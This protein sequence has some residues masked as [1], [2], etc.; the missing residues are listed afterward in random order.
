M[1]TEQTLSAEEHL[2]E[3][4]LTAQEKAWKFVKIFVVEI[5][6][7][8]G[9]EAILRVK[10]KYVLGVMFAL[11]TGVSVSSSS[12]SLSKVTTLWLRDSQS[13]KQLHTQHIHVFLKEKLQYG[14]WNEIQRK[15][16]P[17]L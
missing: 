10:E 9:M 8:C 1:T 5:K 17:S 11:L 4:W 16:A 12:S 3:M 13:G 14:S 2:V 6:K 15:C 7:Y